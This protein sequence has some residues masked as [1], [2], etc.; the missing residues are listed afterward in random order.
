MGGGG[1]EIEA[2]QEAGPEQRVGPSV[3]RPS[4]G[5]GMG[6][7]G[8]GDLALLGGTSHSDGRGNS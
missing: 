6:E 5:G 7:P 8:D 1:G 3:S 2:Q 4:P